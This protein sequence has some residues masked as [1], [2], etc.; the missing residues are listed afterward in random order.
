MMLFRPGRAANSTF[1]CRVTLRYAIKRNLEPLND[2]LWNE[3]PTPISAGTHEKEHIMP[4]AIA[5]VTYEPS[6]MEAA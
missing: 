3:I 4:R 6:G 5:T 1:L 2:L